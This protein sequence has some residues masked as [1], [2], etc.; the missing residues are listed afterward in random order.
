MV[1]PCV[2]VSAQNKGQYNQLL[3]LTE[4]AALAETEEV[5]AAVAEVAGE[6]VEVPL[7]AVAAAEVVVVD[8][9]VAA[10]DELA[11]DDEA[12]LFDEVFAVVPLL[13]LT[14]T[15]QFF[16]SCTAGLPFESVIGVRVM[17]QVCVR[18]PAGLDL[19]QKCH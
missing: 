11:D 1:I 16:T 6:T 19:G 15:V 17:T 2:S 10:S 18:G 9:A 7:S 5:D 8:A 3:T 13:A 4:I 12:G 14:A